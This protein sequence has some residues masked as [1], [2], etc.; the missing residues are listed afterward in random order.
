M[1]QQQQQH[2]LRHVLARMA[3]RAIRLEERL[4]ATATA[5]IEG[6]TQNDSGSQ[7]KRKFSE[8][9]PTLMLSLPPP[10]ST[11]RRKEEGGPSSAEATPKKEEEKEENDAAK[12][13]EDESSSKIQE[14]K[15][16]ASTDAVTAAT[17]ADSTPKTEQEHVKEGVDTTKPND[18][19]TTDTAADDVTMGDVTTTTATAN[20]PGGSEK[21]EEETK[22]ESTNTEAEGYKKVEPLTVETTTSETTAATTAVP[23]ESN[24]GEEEVPTNLE[25][26]NPIQYSQWWYKQQIQ[27]TKDD[28]QR[29]NEKRKEFYKQQIELWNTYTYGLSTIS[30]VSDLADA[31]DAILPGNFC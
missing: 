2:R 18:N 23:A 26:E 17:N 3:D 11:R 24:E 31:P 30:K 29:I 25:F 7:W 5:D 27:Q 14:S 10:M 15:E 22:V 12:N 28:I 13:D 9:A 16:A 8:L 21:K 1:S 20:E 4:D 6:H 19:V